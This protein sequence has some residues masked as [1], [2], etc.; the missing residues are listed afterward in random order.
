M[1]L[2]HLEVYILSKIQ[3]GNNTQ[4]IGLGSLGTEEAICSSCVFLNVFR[5][6]QQVLMQWNQ[7]VW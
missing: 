7:H 2:H 4:V 6:T 1:I 5:D 3:G